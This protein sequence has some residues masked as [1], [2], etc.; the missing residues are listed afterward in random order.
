MFIVIVYVIT[1][2]F[3]A[4]LTSITIIIISRYVVFDRD[5]KT[6]MRKRNNPINKHVYIAK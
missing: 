1:R 2:C 3:S 6:T 5:E 4:E